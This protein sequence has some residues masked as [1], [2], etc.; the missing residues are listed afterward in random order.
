[1]LDNNTFFINGSKLDTIGYATLAT[2]FN[3]IRP[4]R[5][6]AKISASADC[7]KARKYYSKHLGQHISGEEY[8]MHH[9]QDGYIVPVATELHRTINH[10]GGVQLFGI[11]R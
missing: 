8:E 7:K 3:N 6:N 9:T 4:Y 11:H 2:V 10:I 1:M 5:I